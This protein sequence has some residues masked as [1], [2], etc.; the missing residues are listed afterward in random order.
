MHYDTVQHCAMIQRRELQHEWHRARDTERALR[1]PMRS[2]HE[3]YITIQFLYFEGGERPLCH[4]M[5]IARM[6]QLCDM[7]HARSDTVRQALRH[8]AQHGPVRATTRRCVR[9]LGPFGVHP[10]H[11]T[12]F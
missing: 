2:R 6:T 9:G 4:D 5:A 7:A 1:S 11:V 3:L 12:R 10:V 8:D